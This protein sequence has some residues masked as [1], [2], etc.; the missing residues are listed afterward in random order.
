MKLGIILI[1]GIVALSNVIF[2]LSFYQYLSFKKNIDGDYG[3]IFTQTENFVD[4]ETADYKNFSSYD[5]IKSYSYIFA[6]QGIIHLK[7]SELFLNAGQ[8]ELADKELKKAN[9]GK[10]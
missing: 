6:K 3:P 5:Q 9:M 8:K 7:L 2:L 4:Q 10:P 1:F